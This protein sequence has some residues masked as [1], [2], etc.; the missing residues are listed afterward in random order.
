MNT[1]SSLR[2]LIV[3][4]LFSAAC[5]ASPAPENGVIVTSTPPGGGAPAASS[6][7]PPGVVSAMAPASAKPGP[8]LPPPPPDIIIHEA[9]LYG[10]LS[11]HAGKTATISTKVITTK[12]E[13]EIGNKGVLHQRLNDSN[14]D[15]WIP[16]ADV[17]V[18]SKLDKQSRITVTITAEK[19]EFPSGQKIVPFA[20]KS[21]MRLRWEWQ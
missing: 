19:K 18:K 8:A 10:E 14:N 1:L 9:E 6:S 2:L 3:P 15:V 17:V 11:A 16:V 7:A 12:T 13:P 20:P 5:G 21:R 4:V